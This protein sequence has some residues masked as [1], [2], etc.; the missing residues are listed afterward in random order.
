M[1][2]LADLM[3]RLGS[4]NIDCRQDGA[5]LDPTLGRASYNAIF[6]LIAET[7]PGSTVIVDAWFGFQP[8]EVL[9]AGLSRAGI[10]E[11]LELW[12]HAPPETIGARY[13]DRVGTRPAGHPGIDYV[14]E[15]IALAGRARPLAGG[16]VREIDTTRPLDLPGL[17]AWVA[18]RFP[19]H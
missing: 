5:K 10:G 8:S 12:C 2:A 6:D 1:F 16:P 15:L 4:R 18:E 19:G 7:A 9:E 13:A 17:L 3:G 14:P 11:T